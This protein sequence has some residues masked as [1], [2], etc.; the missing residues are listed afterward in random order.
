MFILALFVIAKYYKP[1]CSSVGNLMDELWHV[2]IK[3]NKAIDNLILKH[4]SNLES[5]RYNSY[6]DGYYVFLKDV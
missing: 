4:V 2:A 5:N 1:K 6:V 3:N